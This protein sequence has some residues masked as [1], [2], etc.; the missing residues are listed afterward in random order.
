MNSIRKILHAMAL[1]IIILVIFELRYDYHRALQEKTV[2]SATTPIY[3]SSAASTA[4]SSND[5][6]ASREPIVRQHIPEDIGGIKVQTILSML[7]EIGFWLFLF[8]ACLYCLRARCAGKPAPE[9]TEAKEGRRCCSCCGGGKD[10]DEKGKKKKK[11]ANPEDFKD[12]AEPLAMKE[13]QIASVD[14]IFQSANDLLQSLYNLNQNFLALAKG[15]RD[16]IGDDQTSVDE[17]FKD[18]VAKKTREMK[19]RVTNAPHDWKVLIPK[20]DV[21]ALI[22]GNLVIVLPD[23]ENTAGFSPDVAK[24]VNAFRGF[25]EKLITVVKENV[26]DLAMAIRGV[27]AEAMGVDVAGMKDEVTEAVGSNPFAIMGTINAL[28]TN[29][30]TTLSL[31]SLL[32]VLVHNIKTLVYGLKDGIY[33]GLFSKVEEARRSRIKV[34]PEPQVMIGATGDEKTAMPAAPVKTDGAP[35]ELPAAG[36]TA[37]ETKPTAKEANKTSDAD[38]ERPQAVVVGAGT[39]STPQDISKGDM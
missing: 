34:A 29:L 12:M 13:T 2:T 27:V 25:A 15:I 39:E 21:A 17:I 38:Q 5:P 26:P 11:K 14:S 6:L 23:V 1:L 10:A 24:F 20:V 35:G 31:K 4:P 3:G 33:Q 32:E 9:G 8:E 16:Q 19:E 30:S 28:K 36:A 18:W 7:P 22:E 37:E